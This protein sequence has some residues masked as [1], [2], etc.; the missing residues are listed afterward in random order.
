MTQ[1]AVEIPQLPGL[2]NRFGFI[3]VY[4]KVRMFEALTKSAIIIES[5]AKQQAPSRTGKLR[6]S[7]SF[8]VERKLSGMSAV[9]APH[10]KYANIVE[11]GRGVVTPTNKKVLA[12]KI[13]PGWG[14]KNKAGYFIIGKS[15][16]AVPANPYMGR[17]ATMGLPLA[18]LEFKHM[19]HD[20]TK[21]VA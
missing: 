1:Y 4:T 17:A 6:S 2:T 11:E 5:L 19:A 21:K 18:M 7:I 10:A 16:K 13:N 15:S 3:H 8:K 14:T 20:I 12:T 9:I